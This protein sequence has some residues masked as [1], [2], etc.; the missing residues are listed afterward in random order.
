MLN[1]IS[2]CCATDK[3]N[4]IA[5][6]FGYLI[7]KIN[8]HAHCGIKY[9]PS[10]T[11]AIVNDDCRSAIYVNFKT[12][13]TY[14]ITDHQ[15]YRHTFPIWV[16]DNIATVENSCGTGCANVIIFVSPATAFTCPGYDYRIRFLRENEPP[17]YYHN[18]PLLIDPKR[19]I[20]VCYDNEKNIQIYPLPTQ[21]TIH[22]PTGYFSEKAIIRDDKIVVTYKNRFDKTKQLEYRL[23]E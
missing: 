5:P 8:T 14:R 1:W 18:R 13:Q 19:N 3:N 16:N 22:P 6:S 7:K 11:A 21:P 15:L 10:K 9:N 20:Y 2:N 23:N 12:R 17:D 4:N